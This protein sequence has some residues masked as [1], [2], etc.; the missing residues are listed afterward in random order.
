MTTSLLNFI[1]SFSDLIPLEQRQRYAEPGAIPAIS[2]P[3]SPFIRVVLGLRNSGCTK[4][5]YTQLFLLFLLHYLLLC[6][7]V[8]VLSPN[9]LWLCGSFHSRPLADFL[10]VHFDSNF[11]DHA[12]NGSF[13]CA[14]HPTIITHL[15]ICWK[16]IYQTNLGQCITASK[17]FS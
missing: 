1:T 9:I 7:K 17:K 10:R 14:L 5:Y 16:N 15:S 11:E 3:S 13:W 12:G 4:E 8:H 2:G 6:H